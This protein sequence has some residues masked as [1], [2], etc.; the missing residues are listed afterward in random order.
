MKK[1]ILWL[2]V[3]VLGT[4]FGAGIYEARIVVPEWINPDDYF[5]NAD[6]ANR[7]DT[8]LRFWIYVTS[9]PLTLLTLASMVSLYNS[10]GKLR[11]W[12][13]IAA[14]AALIDR[15]MTFGYF[16]PTMLILMDYGNSE[17]ASVVE[18]AI[19]WSDLNYLRI[20]FVLVAWL[21]AMKALTLL[22][23]HSTTRIKTVE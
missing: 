14:G 20:A 1:L 16:V 21:A 17:E 11:A 7:S 5:W 23:S 19:F 10:S 15:I 18:S 2:F 13:G 3:V 22:D 4:T 9:I 6:A 8:G 12:W